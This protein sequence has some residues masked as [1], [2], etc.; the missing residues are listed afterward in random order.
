MI[1]HDA[2]YTA[3]RSTAKVDRIIHDDRRVPVAAPRIII[4][5]PKR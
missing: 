2:T 3:I 4:H 5:D 1:I